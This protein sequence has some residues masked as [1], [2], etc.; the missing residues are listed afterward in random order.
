MAGLAWPA[1]YTSNFGWE[2]YQLSTSSGILVGDGLL[3][4]ES[5]CFY[6]DKLCLR[7]FVL[8]L[9]LTTSSWVIWS[10]IKLPRVSLW[11]T[12]I[13]LC[14]VP[15]FQRYQFFSS[16]LQSNIDTKRTDFTP[17]FYH[18]SPALIICLC[19]QY[20]ITGSRNPFCV[21]DSTLNA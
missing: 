10:K 18:Q 16:L 3:S 13:S 1:I 5:C 14:Q 4:K 8:K 6:P 19:N 20:Q 15:I 11:A 7:F 12:N 21:Q 9:L 2:L 17:V